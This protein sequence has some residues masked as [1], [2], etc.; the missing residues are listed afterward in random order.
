MA[1]EQTLLYVGA[2]KSASAAGLKTEYQEFSVDLDPFARIWGSEIAGNEI[3]LDSTPYVTDDGYVFQM[4]DAGSLISLTAENVS[5]L[6]KI[7]ANYNLTKS[8]ISGLIAHLRDYVDRDDE[9][10]LGGA[11]SK[12]YE[13]RGVLPPT[14]RFLVTPWQLRNVKGWGVFLKNTP[15]FFNEVSIYPG[16]FENYNFMTKKRLLSI[17]GMDESVVNEIIKFR[18]DSA[19]L[20]WDDVEKVTG[21]VREQDV[22]RVNYIPT[23][24]LRIKIKKIGSSLSNWASVTMT[25]RSNSAPWEFDYRVRRKDYEN[26]AGSYRHIKEISPSRLF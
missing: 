22:F 5:G 11:E 26:D 10:T 23:R 1:L 15:E 19:F 7:L 25:P 21:F 4:Q 16:E 14:N 24:Y 6:S 2:T 18:K 13:S 9:P 20:K 8:E 12:D 3:R 17:E